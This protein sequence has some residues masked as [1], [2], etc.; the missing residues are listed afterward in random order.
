MAFWNRDF[1]PTFSSTPLWAER[2]LSP[3]SDMEDM[4]DRFRREFY[5]PDVFKTVEGFSPRIEVKETDKNIHI[6][7][8]LPGMKE[9]DINVTLRENNLIIEGEKKSEWKKENKGYYRSELNYG[10]F[11]RSIP[12]NTEVDADKVE[13]VYKNG[14][15]EVTLNKMEE[16]KLSAKR[17]EIKH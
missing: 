11:Y 13:A 5:S 6:L 7:A 4:F 9:K 2:A 12:L 1:L 16:S 17:I 8:E 15:L 3:L 10:S 14:I